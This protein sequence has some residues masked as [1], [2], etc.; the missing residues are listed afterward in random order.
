MTDLASSCQQHAGQQ[1][2]TEEEVDREALTPLAGLGQCAAYRKV[3]P[4]QATICRASFRR[5][6]LLPLPNTVSFTES[7]SGKQCGSRFRAIE[8]T[9]IPITND[10]PIRGY[11]CFGYKCGVKKVRYA[12]MVLA[13]QIIIVGIWQLAKLLHRRPEQVTRL[14]CEKI[15]NVHLE[16][17]KGLFSRLERTNRNYLFSE[18]YSRQ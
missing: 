18:E 2:G 12:K 1:R 4:T 9:T 5:L 16:A 10:P 8:R 7:L 15:G 11:R 14:V 13:D 17:K 3:K 6:G